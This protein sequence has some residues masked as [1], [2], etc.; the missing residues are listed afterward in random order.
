MAGIQSSSSSAFP[1]KKALPSTSI[2]PR[3]ITV[4]RLAAVIVARA[5]LDE[6]ANALSPKKAKALRASEGAAALARQEGELWR[7][8]C[9]GYADF[10][11]MPAIKGRRESRSEVLAQRLCCVLTSLSAAIVDE[12]RKGL[13]LA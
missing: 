7:W 10:L 13:H 4:E 2:P 3:G 1:Q 6:R 11:L 8:L 5:R 9:A 12:A